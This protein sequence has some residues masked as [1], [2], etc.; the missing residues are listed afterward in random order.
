MNE[1]T[2]A[3]LVI[4]ATIGVAIFAATHRDLL[5]PS[6]DQHPGVVGKPLQSR[7]P[8][9]RVVRGGTS[10][11]RETTP[12][13]AEAV[14]TAVSG[15]ATP[16]SDPEMVAL[17]VIAKL[18]ADDLVT[19]TKALESAFG[20]RAGSSKEYKRVQAKFKIAQAE[21]DPLVLL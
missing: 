2:L 16:Q 15:I 5:F 9:L 3:I 6:S 11:R 14:S 19:E 7:R 8:A 4:L 12:K 10:A 1:G 21:L 13:R 20:V 18:V 17:R